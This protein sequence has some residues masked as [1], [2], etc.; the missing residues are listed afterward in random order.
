MTGADPPAGPARW[1]LVGWRDAKGA[2]PVTWQQLAAAVND[3]QG[4]CIRCGTRHRRYGPGGNPLCENCRPAPK[5]S[6]C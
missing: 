3:S 5:E 2:P 4:P 1:V 6:Q